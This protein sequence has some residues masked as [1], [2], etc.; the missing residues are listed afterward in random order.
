MSITSALVKELREKTGA[1]ILDC[2]K[3]LTE[4]NGDIPAAIEWL[5]ENGMLK[6]AK[7]NDRVAAEGLCGIASDATHAVIYEVNA[8]TD[9]VAQNEKFLDLLTTV[10]NALLLEK[11]ATV[12]D[13]LAVSFDGE[14]L[15]YIINQAVSI[16]GEKISLRRFQIFE[17]PA[18][19]AFGLYLHMGG[20]IATVVLAE[21]TE[22][23]AKDIALH[24]AGI[25]PLLVSADDVSQEFLEAKRAE[26]MAKV[27]EEGKPANIADKI[28]EGQVSKFLKESVLLNQAFIKNPDVTIEQYLAENNAK[29]L[30]FTRYAVGEGIEK[31]EVDF[32]TEVMNQIR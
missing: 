21:S 14:T 25:N 19:G 24:V 1:G 9:F 11:P 20:R 2:K 28:V 22:E 8:E 26:F 12:E 3:A 6:A 17:K 31:A 13:A 29:V 15:E 27:I 7:K 23:V 5:Q 18:Q 30:S 10:G 4:V 32:A 16:I